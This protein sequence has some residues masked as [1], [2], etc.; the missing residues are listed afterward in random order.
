MPYAKTL[1]WCWYYYMSQDFYATPTYYYKASISFVMGTGRS[2]ILGI[3]RQLDADVLSMFINRNV[4]NV[5]SSRRIGCATLLKKGPKYC[6][7]VNGFSLCHTLR[8]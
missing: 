6:L 2:K 5:L 3:N 7:K 4:Y 8:L 1:I